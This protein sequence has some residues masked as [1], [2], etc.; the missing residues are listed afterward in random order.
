MNNFACLEKKTARE[1]VVAK[2]YPKRESTIKVY[3][4]IHLPWK[5]YHYTP[6][7][8]LYI[9]KTQFECKMWNVEW[10]KN[11]FFSFINHFLNVAKC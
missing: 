11:H 10:K 3:H 4:A 2:A 1:I 9:V 6:V 7:C 8:N 5:Q